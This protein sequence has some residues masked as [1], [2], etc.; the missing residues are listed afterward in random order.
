MPVRLSCAAAV[1]ALEAQRRRPARAAR[2]RS[3]ARRRRCGP[4]TDDPRLEQRE[5]AEELETA[6]MEMLGWDAGERRGR[7]REATLVRVVVDREH[8]AHAVPAAAL[9]RSHQAGR[10]RGVPVVRHQDVRTRRAGVGGGGARQRDEA[11][12]VVPVAAA[13]HRRRA[14]GA[15]RARADRAGAGRRAAR[16]RP[17]RKRPRSSP[18]GS[19]SATPP[20]SRRGGHSGCSSSA[21]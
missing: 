6:R 11:Q 12:A 10:E 17:T 1:D 9:P 16:G 5:I 19:E 13:R 15:R 7:A 4:R 21:R 2:G 20:A 14:P 3:S 8:A 18:C